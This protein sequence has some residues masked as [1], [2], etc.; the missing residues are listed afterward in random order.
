MILQSSEGTLQLHG[1]QPS[2]HAFSQIE[3]QLLSEI[4]PVP[5]DTQLPTQ[6]SQLL[7]SFSELF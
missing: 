7:Q 1:L 5:D 2:L 6:I 4:N 3:V